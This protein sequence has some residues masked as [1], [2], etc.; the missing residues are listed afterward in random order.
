MRAS[1][2]GDPQP[3]NSQH[4]ALAGELNLHPSYY[5]EGPTEPELMDALVAG[6]RKQWGGRPPKDRDDAAAVGVELVDEVDGLG[7]GLV[8]EVSKEG[9][10][11]SVNK[12][13]A[14]PAYNIVVYS[15]QWR[16]GYLSALV[17]FFSHGRPDVFTAQGMRVVSGVPNWD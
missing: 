16:A 6:L 8:G 14:A 17:E 4:V 7:D 3:L 5:I 1:V 13:K 10:I 15:R 12:V 2:F 9:T 11:A